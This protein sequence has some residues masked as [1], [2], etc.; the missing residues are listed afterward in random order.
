MR[1]IVFFVLFYSALFVLA[2]SIQEKAWMSPQYD[3][4]GLAFI[5]LFLSI[6]TPLL[7]GYYVIIGHYMCNDLENDT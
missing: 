5:V 3:P 4:V 6:L 1:M 7:H 2:L